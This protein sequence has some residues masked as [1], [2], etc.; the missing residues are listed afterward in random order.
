MTGVGGVLTEGRRR[1]SHAP[2]YLP[3]EAH[4]PSLLPPKQT[5][6]RRQIKRRGSLVPAGPEGPCAQALPHFFCQQMFIGSDCVS[7]FIHPQ[8]VQ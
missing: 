7:G 8:G 2:A 5:G 6:G 4:C 1:P 3:T